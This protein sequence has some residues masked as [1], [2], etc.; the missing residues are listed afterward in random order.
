MNEE[1]NSTP[2]ETGLLNNAINLFSSPAKAWEAIKHER[3]S[4]FPLVIIVLMVALCQWLYFQSVDFNWFIEQ[5]V[6][7][8]GAHSTPAEKEFMANQFAS[9]GPSVIAIS[10]ILAGSVVLI[11]LYALTAVLL[12]IIS[13]IRD[14]K[15]T[16]GDCFAL[17]SWSGLVK[18]LT[19]MITLVVIALD[20]SGQLS[21]DQLTLLNLNWLFFNFEPGHPWYNW[22]SQ[23]DLTGLWAAALMGFGYH[24]FTKASITASMIIGFLPTVLFFG[25]T[26]LFI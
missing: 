5:Q 13:N 9:M 19:L 21:Q 8:A 1:N 24:K 25:I 3:G 7:A 6:A 23:F 12:L 15:L 18:M 22:L 11:A 4:W 14:D 26:A 2:Q 20:D 16:Y 17:V 10:S